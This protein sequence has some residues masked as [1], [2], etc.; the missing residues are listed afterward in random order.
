MTKV[1]VLSYN[2]TANIL[3]ILKDGRKL[4]YKGI[5]PFLYEKLGKLISRKS[6]GSVDRLVNSWKHASSMIVMDVL[7]LAKSL[8]K[9]SFQ[10][11][12]TILASTTA[13]EADKEEAEEIVKGGLFGA[14][15]GGLGKAIKTVLVESGEWGK[16]EID[17][18][19]L[20]S[21]LWKKIREKFSIRRI[22]RETADL[23]IKKGWKFA[24]MAILLEIFEDVVLPMLAIYLGFPE[25]APFFLALHLEPVV[26]PIALKVL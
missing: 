19:K 22:A 9:P 5:S 7:K 23:A 17:M 16:H 24:L 6:W 8:T 10:E 15:K 25:L 3:T 18:R 1:Q 21:A 14:L 2:Q 20:V 12:V 11:A 4:E 26:Y 13:A